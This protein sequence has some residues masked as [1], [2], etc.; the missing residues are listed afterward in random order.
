M[1]R[2]RGSIISKSVI[3]SSV[4]PAYYWY[5]KS[6]KEMLPRYSIADE[7]ILAL[8]TPLGNLKLN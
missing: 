1:E 2:G 5:R 8:Q 4:L 3:V 7:L 6:K